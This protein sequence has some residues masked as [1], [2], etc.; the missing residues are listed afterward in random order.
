MDPYI[1]IKEAI[2][3]G[4]YEPGERLTEEFLAKE[5]NLSRTPIREAIKQLE[6]EGLITPLKRGVIVRNFTKEDIRQIYDLRALLESYAASQAAYHRDEND[7]YHMKKAN[8]E[9]KE[10][11][12]KIGE[13]PNEDMILEL[14]E[15]NRA[16]HETI[17]A[18]SKN[19]H[20]RFHLSKVVVVPLVFRSFYW[21]DQHQ[22]KHSLGVHETILEAI[23]N[24]DA[25]RAKVAMNE[26][27]F[28][29]RDHVLKHFDTFKIQ[30][31]EGVVK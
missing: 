18:A 9:Y 30:I 22:I 20:L 3:T 8:Q 23:L 31:G 5:T 14:V 11:I 7:L 25:E 10:V 19:E 16:F 6:A 13:K 2:V 21:Y 27:I 29:G 24:N 12:D 26:H 28:Q 15:V 17:L 1:F 4:K